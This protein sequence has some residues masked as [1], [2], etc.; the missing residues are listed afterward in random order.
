[1]MSVLRTPTNLRVGYIR[2]L[3]MRYASAT[4]VPGQSK[5]QLQKPQGEEG[6]FKYGRNLSRDPKVKSELK[7]QKGDTPARLVFC[8]IRF[9]LSMPRKKGN[10][11]YLFSF[12]F[13]RLGHAYEVYPLIFLAGFWFTI[14]CFTI[15]YSFTKI[16]VWVDR[17]NIVFYFMFLIVVDTSIFLEKFSFEQVKPTLQL[18]GSVLVMTIGRRALLRKFDFEGRTR[19]RCELMEVLQDE[20]LE[21]AK[22][23]GTR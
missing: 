17:S 10:I 21:A 14:C 5:I 19:K 22:K 8:T 11:I 6:F 2:F 23:R 13:R 16:E 20:M 15:Y 18:I 9:K 7:A 4:A 3:S 1:M 12:M